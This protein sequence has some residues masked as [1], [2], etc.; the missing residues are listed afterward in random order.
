MDDL[1]DRFDDWLV[2]GAEGEPPR[3]LAVHASGCDACLRSLAAVDS[4]QAIDIGEASLP[5]LGM[6]AT[7][8]ESTIRTL[9]YAVGAV[10][11]V[12]LGGS[13]AIGA[14]GLL[15]P[16]QLGSPQE[17]PSPGAGVLSGVPP[18]AAASQPDSEQPE[19]S[20]SDSGKP[21]QSPSEGPAV[22]VTTPAP[23]VLPHITP[24]PPPFGT[25]RP[26]AAPTRTPA[27]T[28]A[29]TATP[30]VTPPPTP[31]ASPSIVVP[32]PTPT[33]EPTPTATPTPPQCS[34]GVD[35]DGDTLIDFAPIGGDP[36]CT[37]PDDDS[38][39]ELAPP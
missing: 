36:G 22:A 20:A 8:R 30:I 35:N 31:S 3:D 17:T 21:K 25:P 7:D 38:E 12:L 14:F 15:R 19:A 10:A 4:L 16:A 9:R 27:P 39:E 1:H 29:P 26:T 33:L 18:G 34:D 32:T 24:T 5:P 6:A 11:V 13:V 37:S 28:A 23:Q 2:A